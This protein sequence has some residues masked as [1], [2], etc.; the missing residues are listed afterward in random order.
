M[1]R[2]SQASPDITK[3]GHEPDCGPKIALFASWRATVCGPLHLPTQIERRDF[4]GLGGIRAGTDPGTHPG[5]L[6]G[7][8]RPRPPGG[9]D[10]WP[11]EDASPPGA[12]RHAIPGHH[13][14]FC[15][16][17]PG[18]KSEGEPAERAA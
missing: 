18:L 5:R 6:A 12:G 15:R 17:Y 3:R 16:W 10:L 4:C 11:D 9:P 13:H 8:T 7:G 2:V 1:Y 14:M